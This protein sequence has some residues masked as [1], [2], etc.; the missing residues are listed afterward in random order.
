M[1]NLIGTFSNL[2]IIILFGLLYTSCAPVVYGPTTQALPGL[3]KKGD[4]KA[5]FASASSQHNLKSDFSTWFPGM[6][7]RIAYSPINKLGVTL[8]YSIFAEKARP[9]S[10]GLFLNTSERFGGHYRLVDLGVGTYKQLNPNWIWENYAMLS[11]G[12]MQLEDSETDKV[13][14]NLVKAGI[15][16]GLLYKRKVV[17]IG[18]TSKLSRLNYSSI[19]GRFIHDGYDEVDRLRKNNSHTMFEP[20]FIFSLGYKGFKLDF[21]MVSSVKLN[22]DY[23]RRNKIYSSLGFSMAFNTKN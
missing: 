1:K 11:Y 12:K 10:N 17:E 14:A 9:A 7:T 20:G 4:I 19:E 13:N 23:F 2:I 22:R 3:E 5:S 6:D 21:Q 15:V 8:G 16:T 18:V